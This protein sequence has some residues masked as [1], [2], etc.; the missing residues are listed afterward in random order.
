MQPVD[1]HVVVGGCVYATSKACLLAD[2]AGREG[3]MMERAGR[4]TFLFRAPPGIYF[5]EHRTA[6]GVD[7]D[8]VEVLTPVDA[9]RLYEDLP[10]HR[11]ELAAAFE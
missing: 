9:R 10:V 11:L 5:A 6:W 8:Y 1:M 7:A 4:N 3:G 2:D